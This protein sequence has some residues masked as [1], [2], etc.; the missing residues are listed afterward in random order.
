M[1]FFPIQHF[2]QLKRL[3]LQNN[4]QTAKPMNYNLAQRARIPTPNLKIFPKKSGD[5]C[6]PRPSFSLR[7]ICYFLVFPPLHPYAFLPFPL[8]SPVSCFVSLC[9][10]FH[11]SNLPLFLSFYPF[12]FN[13]PPVPFPFPFTLERSAPRT[14][15]SLSAAII[16]FLPLPSLFPPN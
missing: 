14:K 7:V 15:C 3:K 12:T 5:H 9:S 2:D 10:A 11:H 6:R 16:L 1:S 8:L 13:L 4:L